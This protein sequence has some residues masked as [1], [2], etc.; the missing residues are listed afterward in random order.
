MEKRPLALV[1]GAS[2]G[3]GL[4]LAKQFA[5]HGYDLA[6]SG[7]SDKIFE[8]ALTLRKLGAEAFPYQADA[9]VYDGVEGFWKFTSELGRP[10]E[11]AVLNV[12]IAIGGSFVENQLEDDLRVIAV[13][14]TG[15]VHMAKRAV[16]HMVANGR[17]RIL[18]VSSVSATQPTPFETVY[19][20]SK[21][22]GFSLA[23]SLR[24]E[25]RG[26]GVTVSAL[27]P[28]ATATKFHVNAGMAETAIGRMEKNDPRLVA[29][30][31]YDALMNDEDHV[32]GGDEA[33]KKVA[34]ENRTTPEPVKAAR[35]AV[36][37]RLPSSPE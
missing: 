25:L 9:A 16:Q 37:S 24:E 33:T 27:L 22:F 5:G 6:I 15:T 17:G 7:S 30:Q 23:E 36:A 29:K 21:A 1:T 8:A 4:E 35:H 26:T 11:A 13:N 12:G 19:G 31:G 34:I 10:I 3:I 28:G 18:I 32:V 20:P 2:S 14:V